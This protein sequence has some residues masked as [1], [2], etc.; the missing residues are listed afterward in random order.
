[1]KEIPIAILESWSNKLNI[2]Q[3]DLK[4]KFENMNIN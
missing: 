3:E 1:M 2:S 4:K